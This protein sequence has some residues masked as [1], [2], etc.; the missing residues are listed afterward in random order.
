M[1]QLQ[2]VGCEWFGESTGQ[3]LCPRQCG[4]DMRQAAL[5]GFP[6][7]PLADEWTRLMLPP[8]VQR[9]QVLQILDRLQIVE[10]IKNLVGKPNRFRELSAQ[11]CRVRCLSRVTDPDI[12]RQLDE[13]CRFLAGGG[14]VVSNAHPPTVAATV[15]LNALPT[16]D[17]R[18]CV[19]HEA[20]ESLGDTRFMDTCGGLECRREEQIPRAEG[21]IVAIQG[22][23][24]VL[25][26]AILI[27]IADVVVN[28]RRVMQ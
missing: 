28:K 16:D 23:H 8:G 20:G 18:G 14:K 26:P 15:E 25:A 4:L 22:T 6:V 2:N 1:D 9:M 19:S 11:R 5:A 12:Q 27:V 24:G 17:T 10:I 13:R 7:M 21:D 3:A